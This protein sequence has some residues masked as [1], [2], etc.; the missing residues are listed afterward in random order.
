MVV[1]SAPAAAT[2]QTLC[3]KPHQFHLARF[4]VCSRLISRVTL[5]VVLLYTLAVQRNNVTTVITWCRCSG[6]WYPC[7]R[8]R[9]C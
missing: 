3:R 8:C 1:V 6:L 4:T 2:A 5:L 9:R 7:R